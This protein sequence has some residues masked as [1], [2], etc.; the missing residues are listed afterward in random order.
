MDAS[1]ADLATAAGLNTQGL[2]KV[3]ATQVAALNDDRFL[4]VMGGVAQLAN[5]VARPVWGCVFDAFGTRG[6]LTLARRSFCV[7]SSSSTSE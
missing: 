6:P 7:C 5:G 2:Y 4:A 3:H 1:A